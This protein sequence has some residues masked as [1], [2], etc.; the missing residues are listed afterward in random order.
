MPCSPRPAC[1]LH[2][3]ATLTTSGVEMYGYTGDVSYK[4]LHRL[5]V[6]ALA[7]G[8]SPRAGDLFPQG[9][10]SGPAIRREAGL[11]W[12]DALQISP[13]SLPARR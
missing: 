2:G 1:S 5:R 13:D 4:G 3:W 9:V 7:A 8:T 12:I 11:R 6:T 10:G